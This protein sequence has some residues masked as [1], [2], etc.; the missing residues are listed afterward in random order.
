MGVD[1]LQTKAAEA[2]KR[3]L[4]VAIGAF[5]LTEESLR[6][7]V[8]DFKLPKE[9]LAAILES[10]NKTKGD[11]LKTLSREMMSQVMER[12]DPTALVQEL[13]S[14]NEIDLHIKINLKPKKKA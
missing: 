1:D 14:K 3:V 6:G 8:S 5:F 2:M 11:F 10:A 4:T 9:L 7:L 12:V 13:L